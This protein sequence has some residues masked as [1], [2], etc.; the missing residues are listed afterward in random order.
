MALQKRLME[1]NYLAI[2]EPTSYFGNATKYAVK[3]FQREH[4]LQLDVAHG[5]LGKQ[6]PLHRHGEQA[7]QD[8]PRGCAE[9]EATHVSAEPLDRWAGRARP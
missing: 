7:D 6:R 8:D 9:Q 5:V 2:D 1:L 3:L 4:E